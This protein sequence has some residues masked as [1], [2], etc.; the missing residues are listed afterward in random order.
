VWNELSDSLKNEKYNACTLQ[1]SL[2]HQFHFLVYTPRSARS[3]QSIFAVLGFEVRAYTLSTLPVLLCDFFEI[4]SQ[5]LFAQAGF[6]W[7]FS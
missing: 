2:M 1:Y 6:E 3:Q 7:R 5:K 4:G